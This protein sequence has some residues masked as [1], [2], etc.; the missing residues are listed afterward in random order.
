MKLIDS[1]RFQTNRHINFHRL[2]IT[3]NVIFLLLLA[4]FYH[5]EAR[6]RG[7][8]MKFNVK[9]WFVSKLFINPHLKYKEKG[10]SKIINF[11]RKQ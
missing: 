3:F 4:L 2:N 11:G 1:K 8:E 6:K 9:R 7:F 10:N 5:E